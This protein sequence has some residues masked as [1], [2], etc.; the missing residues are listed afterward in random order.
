MLQPRL[1]NPSGMAV[2]IAA[3]L[4]VLTVGLGYAGVR[5]FETVPVEA[6]AVDLVTPAE[7]KEATQETPPKP[8]PPLEIPDLSTADQPAAAA[9]PAVPQPP[10]RQPAQQAMLSAASATPTTEAKQAAIQ[11]PAAAASQAP[12][13]PQ[14]AASWRPPEPDLSVKY[15]VNLGL[16]APRAG[17]F[18]TV[19]FTAAKVSADDI[20]K[21]REHLKTC[22]VLPGSIAPADKVTIR[23]RASFLPDGTLASAPLLIE[24]SASA[25]GPLLMQA[26]IDALAACQPYAV[27]PADKYNEWKVLDLGFTPRDFRG[28]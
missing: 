21:F 16:P 22:S 3:H 9:K 24:A 14:P 28:G 11:P 27:L 26:A 10:P 8:T 15:Q 25:K 18:D 6:I 4:T 17:D 7:V 2:S 13:A 12:A 1:L 20:A 19:A 23:L 5:P